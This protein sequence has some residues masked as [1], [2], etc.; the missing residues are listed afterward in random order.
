MRYAKYVAAALTVVAIA[1]VPRTAFAQQM[2]HQMPA[3]PAAGGMQGMTMQEGPDGL[4]PVFEGIKLT[5]AQKM[6]LRE[7]N[8]A[9]HARMDSV[10]TQMQKQMMGMMDREHADFRA[11]LTAEQ[12]ATF[13]KNLAKHM[14]QMPHGP[15]GMMPPG[16]MMGPGSKGPAGAPP[17]KPPT[18]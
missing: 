5:E 18:R 3:K 1:A 12:Q 7:I 10:R 16:G 13:D 8:R 4:P 17:A 2:D 14:Q 11:A 6:K 15:D 9:S